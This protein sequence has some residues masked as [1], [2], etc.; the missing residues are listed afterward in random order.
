MKYGP[1]EILV[2]QHEADAGA[3]LLGE[4]LRESGASVALCGPEAVEGAA[5][6]PASA[7]GYDGVVVL[8]G[9]PGPADDDR[10]PWLVQA[11]TLIASSLAEA[12][13]LLGVCLGAQLLAYV[14]GGEVEPLSGS[15]EIGVLPLWLTDDAFGDPLVSGLDGPLQAVQWHEL[16]ITALPPGARR[17]CGGERCQ[18]QAFRIGRTAWGVQFHLEAL[19]GIVEEWVRSGTADL[20]AAGIEPEQLVADIRAAEPGLRSLWEPVCDRW[21][22]V[23]S[24]HRESRGSA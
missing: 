8:G 6:I 23:C 18:N 17:L 19:P 24:E 10:A 21:L 3:G 15:P 4:R 22:S 2:V 1:L 13:P 20:A 11:R 9:S 16:E 7:S 14:A 12:V 5:P